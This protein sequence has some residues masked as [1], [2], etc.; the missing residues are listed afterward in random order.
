MG[1]EVLAGVC[2]CQDSRGRP[3]SD[4]LCVG[5]RLTLSALCLGVSKAV[6][7]LQ[8]RSPGFLQ[9][10]HESH[11]PSTSQED[12]SFQW[13]TPE[14]ES[15]KCVAWS[16]HRA[17]LAAAHVIG[18]L[19]VSPPPRDRFFPLPTRLC[20]GFSYCLGCMSLMPVSR[21]CSVRLAPRV[22]LM[23]LFLSWSIA[24]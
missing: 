3:A 7:I 6:H 22:C 5:F 21:Q 20:V 9:P 15:S 11:G 19:F 23:L 1:C 17:G 12:S 18:F 13:W 10:S 24:D 8:E 2:A 4:F 16:T 14:L